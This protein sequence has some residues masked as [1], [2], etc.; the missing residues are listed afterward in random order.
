LKNNNYRKAKMI[1]NS[2]AKDLIV[3]HGTPLYIYDKEW[4]KKR[5]LQILDASSKTN[6][7]VRYAIKAN[8]H[9][10]I[11]RLFDGLGLHF[12]ASSEFE[13]DKLIKQGVDSNK[14]SL[15]SQQPPKDM[16]S[17]LETGV[18]FVATSL[19]QLALIKESGWKDN[20]AVRINPGIGSGHSK[21]TTTGGVS[22]SFGI[23]HEYIPEILAWQKESGIKINRLHIHVG[24]GVDPD[25]W[26]KVI[27]DA[28]EIA[29]LMPTIEILDMGGGYKVARI[30]SEQETDINAV[31]EVFSEELKN[32][33]KRTHRKL[34]LEVEPGTWLVANGGTL[35]STIVDIV[36]TGK[37]G[38]KFIKLDTG[39]NDILR[40]SLY[41]AQHPI[42]ILN[43]ATVKEEYVV[44][45]HN[46]ESGDILT[47]EPG[48]PEQ[49][50]PRLLN[51]ARIGNVVA[52]GGSGAYCASMRAV[53]YND[54]PIAKEIVI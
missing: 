50:K 1:S 8:P 44:V 18:N 7:I 39:M 32:F 49:I 6:C 36:D 21:R 31:M 10:E 53:G 54:F 15:S 33:E 14:I 46:C 16:K 25:I 52:I 51:K 20:I 11:I 34:R 30:E 23:W 41:G 28:L 24:A 22:A 13:A 5:T 43:G 40:P 12:D 37:D 4:F 27:K 45:G 38:Y 42:K 3:A 19:H 26:R 9:P 47:P 48:D 35:L 29:N 2:A 17:V